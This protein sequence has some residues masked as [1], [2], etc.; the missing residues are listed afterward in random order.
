MMARKVC[1]MQISFFQRKCFA[2]REWNDTWWLRK[3]LKALVTFNVRFTEKC[4]SVLEMQL[5]WHVVHLYLCIFANHRQKLGARDLQPRAHELGACWSE[6]RTNR[7]ERNELRKWVN[8]F[9]LSKICK[10]EVQPR[11][12]KGFGGEGK[13]EPVSGKGDDGR[14]QSGAR[15]EPISFSAK[16]SLSIISCPPNLLSHGRLHFSGQFSNSVWAFYCILCERTLRQ[17]LIHYFLAKCTF[18]CAG[19]C[20]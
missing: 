5:R 9:I 8:G 11:S 17:G 10:I 12:L 14:L 18:R 6:D 7:F 3:P 16:A 13:N 1:K 4:K 19:M 15:Y 2:G 20:Y